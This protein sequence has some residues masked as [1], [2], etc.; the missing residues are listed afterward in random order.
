L[1]L[2]KGQKKPEEVFNPQETDEVARATL[3]YGV[4]QWYEHH[5]Q[6]EKAH[7]LL[8]DIIQGK[9]WAAFGYLAAE[10]DLARAAAR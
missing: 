8:Q 1:L 7:A 3:G 10:A 4:A 9:Q 5:N 2:Y 6:P